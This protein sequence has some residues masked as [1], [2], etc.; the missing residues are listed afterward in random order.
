MESEREPLPPLNWCCEHCGTEYEVDDHTTSLYLDMVNEGKYSFT[1]FDCIQQDCGQSS[2]YFTDIDSTNDIALRITNI[3]PMYEIEDWIVEGYKE[4]HKNDS[5][6]EIQAEPEVLA[7]NSLLKNW[8]AFIEYVDP[9]EII[10]YG[11]YRV[12]KP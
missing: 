11:H 12:D 10:E 9:W 6:I 1:Q 4:L 3:Y 2:K 7:I 5:V 8:D